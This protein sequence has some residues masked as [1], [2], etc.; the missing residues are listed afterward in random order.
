TVGA[1]YT[2]R[3]HFAEIAG[4]PPG[5]DVFSVTVNGATVLTGFDVAGWLGAGGKAIVES[6]NTTADSSGTIAIAFS[7]SLGAARCSGIEVVV[8]AN[9][10]ALP[11]AP[12]NFAGVAS[13]YKVTLGWDAAAGATGYIVERAGPSAVP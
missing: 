13:D 7:P 3:L 12:A 8:G 1:G 4:H 6:F 5:R 11:S 2:V 10:A 9:A